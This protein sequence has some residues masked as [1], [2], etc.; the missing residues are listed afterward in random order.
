M[1]KC[2]VYLD[3]NKLYTKRVHHKPRMR[4]GHIAS[5]HFVMD[6]DDTI[7]QYGGPI[8]IWCCVPC[9]GLDTIENGYDPA[10]I[11]VG[12]NGG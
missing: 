9:L 6:D 8:A 5:G 2:A 7:E 4:C 11:A 12:K 3:N 10:R 1:I